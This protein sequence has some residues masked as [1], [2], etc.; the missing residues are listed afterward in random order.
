M[1]NGGPVV[2]SPAPGFPN[3]APPTPAIAI[4]GNA[5]VVSGP[6][7]QLAPPSPTAALPSMWVLPAAPQPAG[8]AAWAAPDRSIGV[9]YRIGSI[10]LASSEAFRQIGHSLMALLVATM[11]GVFARNR[12]DLYA[13]T[14]EHSE[15]A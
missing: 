13:R 12:Y 6:T 1:I 10:A 3:P 11:G 7:Q 8:L 14:E 9:G 5:S 15:P 2:L 4:A